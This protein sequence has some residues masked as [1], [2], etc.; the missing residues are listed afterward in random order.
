MQSLAAY[1]FETSL[2]DLDTRLRA[3]DDIVDE[4]LRHKG[5]ELPR[6][7]EG[8]FVSKTG[9][10]TGQFLRHLVES[11]V[12]NLREIELVET[13]HNGSMFTTSVLVASVGKRIVVFASL[14]ATPGES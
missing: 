7:P 14:Q 1:S 12:G 3:I 10:G 4:W 8:S 9:D 13:A 11:P 6:V 5:A 2:D